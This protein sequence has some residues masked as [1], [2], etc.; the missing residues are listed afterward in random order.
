MENRAGGEAAASYELTFMAVID[1]VDG[2]DGDD[3]ERSLC[4]FLKTAADLIEFRLEAAESD[5]L[6]KPY[7]R[8]VGTKANTYI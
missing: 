7:F 8:S 6:G 2:D 4:T 5:F 3:D 1:C